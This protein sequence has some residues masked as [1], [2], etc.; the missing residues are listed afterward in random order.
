MTLV[1]E[2]RRLAPELAAAN[3]E[4]DRQR[5]MPETTWKS[6]HVAGLFRALQPAR[7]GGGEVHLREFYDAVIEVSRASGSAG[8]VMGVIGVHPWQ[9]ALFPEKTQKEMWG[10]DASRMHSSSYSPTGKA[11]K[12]EG[13]YRLSGRWSFS[14][15][16]AHCTAVNVGV[17]A[18]KKDLGGGLEVPDFRSMVVFDGDYSLVDVWHTAGMKGTGSN[19]IVI[20][21]VFVPEY[22]TQSH[23]DYL[24]SS[25]LPGW[26]VNPA[27]LYRTPWAVVFNFAL[28]AS[29]YGTALGYLDTWVKESTGRVGQFG[30]SIVNDPLMQRRVAEFTWDLDAAVAKLQRDSDLMMSAAAAG[31]FLPPEKRAEM[32]W[33]ATRGCEIVGRGVS[34]L[35]HSASGRAI[36]SD[37]PLQRGF[38][39]V[40][41]AL[42]HAFLVGDSISLSVGSA[43]LGGNP[44][45]VM[46]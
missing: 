33:N 30:G 39:D 40:Q 24:T 4:A 17:I 18:G 14:S 16:S 1:D 15:G 42:G 8:W 28:A 6:M 43:R 12:V 11:V 36:F 44:V 7:Y 41:G 3:D 9:L 19:D 2:A 29:V 38:Q 27:A 23:M 5:F 22:R 10:T 21:D 25:P 13:G 46:A 45:P 20:D 32:R 37:H 26:D 31:E 34:E 35:H